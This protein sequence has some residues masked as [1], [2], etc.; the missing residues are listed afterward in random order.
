MEVISKPEAI[1][2][3]L[4]YYF[5]GKPC[6]NGHLSRRLVSNRNCEQCL[7]SYNKSYYLKN[8]ETYKARDAEYYKNN[9]ESVSRRQKQFYEMNPEANRRRR[10]NYKQKHPEK[11]AAVMRS[12]YQRNREAILAKQRERYRREPEKAVAKLAIRRARKQNA[13]PTW[14]GEI[15]QLVWNEAADLA[16]LR[17]AETGFK[18]HVDHMIPLAGES[19]SGLHVWN[20]CQV[21]PMQLNIWKNNKMVMTDVGEWARYL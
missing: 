6:K 3:G 21:I 20:N 11:L 2:Q 18:W 9:K 12:N 15:D 7:K 8:A 13:C 14:F 4:D 19:A 1:A 10:N 17:S 5:T 16:K